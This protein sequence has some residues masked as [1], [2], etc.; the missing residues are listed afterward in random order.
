[1][2]SWLVEPGPLFSQSSTMSGPAGVARMLSAHRSW[3]HH[4]TASG[5]VRNASVATTSGTTRARLSANGAPAASS[6]TI[7]SSQAGWPIGA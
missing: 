7:I 1:M 5:W 4:W 2:S 3:W 6:R